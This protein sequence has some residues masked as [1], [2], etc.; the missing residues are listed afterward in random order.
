[1]CMSRCNK[2]LDD[3]FVCACVYEKQVVRSILF[4]ATH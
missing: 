2:S 3:L 4:Q 1:M